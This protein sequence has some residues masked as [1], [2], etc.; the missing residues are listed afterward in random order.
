MHGG[1]SAEFVIKGLLA[2][3]VNSIVQRDLGKQKDEF[4]EKSK[5]IFGSVGPHWFRG[6]VNVGEKRTPVFAKDMPRILSYFDVDRVI[7][8]HCKYD[9]VYNYR[10]QMVVGI[11]VNHSENRS[12]HKARALLMNKNKNGI[13][14]VRVNMRASLSR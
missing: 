9:N 5:F 12:E 1:I 14:I 2:Q 11:D 8:G 6:M 10:N 13:S 7:V 3:E 4:S